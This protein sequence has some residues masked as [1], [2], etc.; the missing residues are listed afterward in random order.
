M[1]K[2]IVDGLLYRNLD[3]NHVVS[4]TNIVD[5][6]AATDSAIVEESINGI[7]S[8]NGTI[9]IPTLVDN[10]FV[11]LETL[12]I[13]PVISKNDLLR[14]FHSLHTNKI[15]QTN[16]K[17]SF[18]ELKKLMTIS[19]KYTDANRMHT[20]RTYTMEPKG[21]QLSSLFHP[22]VILSILD[23]VLIGVV[24]AE[25]NHKLIKTR[26]LPGNEITVALLVL[27]RIG[28]FGFLLNCFFILLHVIDIYRYISTALAYKLHLGDYK[29]VHYVLVVK[30]VVYM[31]LHVISHMINIDHII[32]RC[33][34]GCQKL[35]VPIVKSKDYPV[36]ISWAYFSRQGPFLTGYILTAAFVSFIVLSILGKKYIRPFAFVW[37]HRIAAVCILILVI[38]HG[39]KHLLGFN[40]SYVFVLPIL[41]VY[42]YVRRAEYLFTSKIRIENWN[43]SRAK[44]ITLRLHK[45][46]DSYHKLLTSGALYINVPSISYLE[47]HP[48]TISTGFSLSDRVLYINVVGEWTNKLSCKLQNGEGMDNPYVNYGRYELSTFRFYVQYKKRVFICS[49]LGITAYISMMKEIIQDKSQHGTTTYFIWCTSNLNMVGMISRVLNEIRMNAKLTHMKMFIYFSNRTNLSTLSVVSKEAASLYLIQTIIHNYFG[50]D[51]LSNTKIPNCIIIGRFNPEQLYMS[52]INRES[53]DITIGIFVCGSKRYC[54][55]LR[56][57]NSIYSGNSKNIT[58]DLWLDEGLS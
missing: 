53:P 44:L 43:T 49:N 39:Y 21:I 30:T 9:C 45:D 56:K 37:I 58:F 3:T 5:I 19:N 24:V 42:L 48:F 38:L 7:V 50:I 25:T 12:R 13:Q 22:L 29:K 27:A 1:R 23:I 47:W 6:I 15:L 40:F 4:Q 55:L 10:M 35:D 33:K 57:L 18:I 34:S 20:L 28:A 46:D 54:D 52:M 26:N 16:N 41:I 14:L 2:A 8:S 32:H 11:A 51:V 36:V 17:I 31:T